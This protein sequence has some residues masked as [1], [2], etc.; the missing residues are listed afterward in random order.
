[1]FQRSRRRAS[2]LAPDREGR[3]SCNAKPLPGSVK[4]PDARLFKP[5][6]AFQPLQGLNDKAGNAGPAQD[7]EKRKA[8]AARQKQGDRHTKPQPQ[9]PG[10]QGEDNREEPSERRRPLSPGVSAL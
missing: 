7:S 6:S 4:E 1:M 5:R 9:V 3:A 8:L 10:F 2:A